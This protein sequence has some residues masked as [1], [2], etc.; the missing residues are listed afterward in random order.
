MAI[1]LAI[2]CVLLCFSCKKKSERSTIYESSG[3]HAY[4]LDGSRGELTFYSKND[5]LFASF[6]ALEDELLKK[7]KKLLFAMNG[8]MFLKDFSPQGLYIEKGE[9]FTPIDN[10]QDGYGNFYLQPNG[11]FYINNDGDAGISTSK[12][13]I[14]K[15]IKYATQSGPMLVIDGKM[16]PAF[17]EGSNNTYVRN[18]VG[19]LPNGNILFAISKEK[20]NF[21]DFAM[22]FKKQ[23]C[24]NALYLDG[25][26]S[27]MY[28]PEKG[29]KQDGQ[30][31]VIIAVVE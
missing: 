15:N 14:P 27:R 17:T 20:I 28:W 31:G 21:Y 9:E 16:H 2:L 1:R 30:F 25:F 6:G 19:I 18:G 4:L 24:K 11:V 8:G 12:Q 22:F 7:N 26:V 5:R 10:Q 13:F 3:I 29:I 23:G